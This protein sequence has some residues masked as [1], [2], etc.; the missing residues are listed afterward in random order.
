[1]S[2]YGQDSFAITLQISKIIYRFN[3]TIQRL[4]ISV[5]FRLKIRL[6]LSKISKM[7]TIQH[8]N[9]HIWSRL[10]CYSS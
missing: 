9:V 4:K 5:T 7:A 1:M 2:I 8:L 6:T 10:P 3:F